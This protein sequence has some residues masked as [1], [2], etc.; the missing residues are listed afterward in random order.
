MLDSIDV[1][2]HAGQDLS[3]FSRYMA[4]RR[5]LSFATIPPKLLMDIGVHNFLLFVAAT[6]PLVSGPKSSGF[7]GK[8]SR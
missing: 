7:F 3:W 6:S 5:E 1:S 4:S 2:T 8:I